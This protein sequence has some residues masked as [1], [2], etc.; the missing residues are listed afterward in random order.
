MVFADTISAKGGVFTSAMRAS[1]QRCAKNS[2]SLVSELNHH[3]D[4]LAPTSA[5]T[6]SSGAKLE[7]CVE[8]ARLWSRELWPRG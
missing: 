7:L 4:R 6:G 3:R 8:G 2:S 1:Q 5:A